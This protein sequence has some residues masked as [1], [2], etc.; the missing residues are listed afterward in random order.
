MRRRSVSLSLS[1]AAALLAL[2]AAGA[3]ACSSPTASSAASCDSPGVTSSEVRLGLLYPDS[4]PTAASMAATRAGV[5][6]RIGQANAA[7][8]IHGR[9]IVYDWRDDQ[10]DPSANGVAA[11]DLIERQKDFGI[12]EYSLAANGSA[13]YLAEHGVPV[14]GLATGDVWAKYRTMFSFSSTTGAATDTYGT[15]L[16]SQGGTKAILLRT[17]LSAGVGN[18]S[19]KMTQSSQAAGIPVVGE[20]A[21]TAGADSPAAVA[22]R[23]AES[24]ADTL[25]TVINAPDLP[26]VLT[27]VRAAGVNLR[28]ILS[29]SGY[30]TQLLHDSAGALAGVTIPVFYRPFEAGGPAIA[31]YRTAMARYA[32]Q[33]PN[34]QQELAMI[35]YIDTDLYLRGL[36][37]AGACPTR[38]GFVNSLNAVHDYDAGG[39]IQPMDLARDRGKQT[40]CWSFV[41]ANHT[42]DAF[43]VVRENL[44]GHELP[45]TTGS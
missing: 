19:A 27:A 29:V 28:A 30:D 9:K 33:V 45:A 37:E 34:P 32:P 40:T 21:Y 12:L 25:L 36:T 18:T 3:S 6:A 4:G 24:G 26:A 23:I 20:I 7:G 15:F 22:R 13:Q 5:D 10:G 1:S 35:A 43:N 2:V 17:A 39:L 8:G 44:C 38:E 42:G 41:Q 14:G 16:R 11:R 31:N